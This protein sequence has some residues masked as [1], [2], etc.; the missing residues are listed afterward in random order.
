MQ[1]RR[2][3][4]ITRSEMWRVYCSDSSSPATGSVEA[5]TSGDAEDS[6]EGDDTGMGEGFGELGIPS[7]VFGLNFANCPTAKMALTD[8]LGSAHST[9]WVSDRFFTAAASRMRS[10]SET[11]DVVRVITEAAP[12]TVDDDANAED[13]ACS[14]DMSKKHQI[15][16]NRTV[17]QNYRINR[18][19][20]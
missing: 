20:Q 7:R 8:A 10:S 12:S 14:D 15:A 5:R 18:L 17:P 1:D 3:G 2:A 19:K 11:I 6:P 4:N 16:T 9:R 13:D